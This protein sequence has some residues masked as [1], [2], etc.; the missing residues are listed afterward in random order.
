MKILSKYDFTLLFDEKLYIMLQTKNIVDRSENEITAYLIPN[1]LMEIVENDYFKN[2]KYDYNRFL[3]L[4][5][6]L[7]ECKLQIQNNDKKMINIINECN[8]LKDKCKDLHIVAL[9][10]ESNDDCEVYRYEMMTEDHYHFMK[11]IPIAVGNKI[12]LYW[13]LFR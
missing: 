13:S 11:D 9:R 7:I 4:R 6:A 3:A 5:D 1:T 2:N 12:K 10:E 8:T